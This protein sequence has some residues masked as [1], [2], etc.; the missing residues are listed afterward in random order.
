MLKPSYQWNKIVL[1]ANEVKMYQIKA[2]E[3]EIKLHL[4]NIWKYF[5][6]G[7]MKNTALCAYMTD[8]SV[9]YENI[10]INNINDIHELVKI[11]YNDRICKS[12][13]N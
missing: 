2:K 4:G 5:T 9:A 13:G 7:N 12:D 1:V 6:V 10:A 11:W 8:F 3:S